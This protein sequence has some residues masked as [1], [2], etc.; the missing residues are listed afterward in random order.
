MNI[1]NA[2]GLIGAAAAGSFA[3]D[4][5]TGE[6][7]M[8]DLST[9]RTQV[10]GLLQKAAYL[11]RQ[12]RLGELPEAQAIAQLNARVA[13]GSPQSVLAVLRQFRVSLD[14]AYEAVRQGMANYDQV[15]SDTRQNFERGL[16]EQ[17]RIKREMAE[18]MRRRAGDWLV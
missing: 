2:G 14:Q 4:K 15:E 16:Q 8:M 1:V 13:S 6:K 7:L 17:E 18:R 9:M 10:D 5:D 12:V 11:D 3:V